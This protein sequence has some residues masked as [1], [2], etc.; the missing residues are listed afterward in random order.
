MLSRVVA[1]I[2]LAVLTACGGESRTDALP[3]N[4]AQTIAPTS[5]G[6]RPSLAVAPGTCI[7]YAA[8]T[9][10]AI[11]AFGSGSPNVSSVL[12]K[13]NN[14][15]N[16]INAGSFSAAR[17][18]GYDIIEFTVRKNSQ[19]ALGGSTTQI[20]AFVNAVSCFSGLNVTINDLDNTYFILPT[21]APQ[22][23]VTNNGLAGISLPGN[24]VTEP[25]ILDIEQIPFTGAPGAGPLDT[26]LDQYPGFYDFQLIS[27]NN[28]G[29]APGVTATIAVCPLPGIPTAILNRLRLGHGASA[30]FEITPPAAGFLTCP[31]SL[32]SNANPGFFGKVA[33]LFTPRVAFAATTTFF[34]GGVGGTVTELSPFAPV[35]P[36]LN[37]GGGG[38]GGTVTELRILNQISANVAQSGCSKTEAPVGASFAPECRPTVTLITELGTKLNGAPI[39]FNVLSGGG[40]TAPQDANGACG[41][42]G[43]MA[44]VNTAL[45]SATACW[46]LG[47][48]PGS[49]TIS[50][51]AA[52][53]GDVPK[54]AVITNNGFVFSAIANGPSA[55][56]FNVQPAAGSPLVAGTNIPVTVTAVDKNGVT[57]AAFSGPVTLS[58]VTGTFAGGL[59]SYTATATAG[60]ASFPSVSITKTGTGYQ[61]RASGTY[62]ST[63]FTSTGNAFEILPAAGTTLAIVSGNVPTQNAL[64]GTVL[65]NNP[66]VRLTDIYSNVVTGA[67]IDWSAG[68]SSGGSVTPL[69]S[70]T[71]ANGQASTVWTVGAGANELRARFTDAVSVL[72]TATGR[73][74]ALVTLNQ[75]LPSGGGDP[76]D[77][78]GATG[79]AFYIPDPRNGNTIRQI[80]LFISAAGSASSPTEYLLELAVQRSTFDTV[81]NPANQR[82]LVRANVF[83]RGSSSEQKAVTFAL[84]TPIVGANGT[85]ARPVMMRL[86][87]VTNPD[88]RKLSFNT[89]P[90]SPGTSCRPPSGC[91]ATEVSSPMPF[92][93]GTFLRRSV[94]ITVS[95]NN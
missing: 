23:L 81:P 90:C 59:T 74:P 38:V 30:G 33:A 24:P 11:D 69:T 25:S 34:G 70:V 2:G 6:G 89:G 58:L 76:F 88:G 10:A 60:V 27:A 71:D 8:L 36:E 77:L 22:T 45:G 72:F 37:M 49:N 39:T 1:L 82:Q 80:T 84:T 64:A 92:P 15:K 62:A 95:G 7:T 68:G 94:A 91:N 78:P 31:V 4:P 86:R 48:T 12:G 5:S 75:C 51:T 29:L 83:L 50:A 63:P 42:S 28:I 55:F 40:R 9:Q 46:T 41:A 21:D 35:D 52:A 57:V 20:L 66:T 93:L 87:A 65:P 53:G 54:K 61:L 73:V 67:T 16:Q 13:L 79:N 32:G 56:A 85:S 18:Q 44:V 47:S 43:T 26:K 19:R 14:L 17:Q 3:T